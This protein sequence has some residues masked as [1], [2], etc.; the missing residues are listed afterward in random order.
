MSAQL[1]NYSSVSERAPAYS[2]HRKLTADALLPYLEQELFHCF[3]VPEVTVSD[4]GV[5]FKSHKFKE[6]LQKYAIHH[7]F[8]AVYAPPANA[9]ESLHKF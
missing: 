9:S 1:F 6:L 3:D 5:Q 8:I 7:S 2:N 4:N